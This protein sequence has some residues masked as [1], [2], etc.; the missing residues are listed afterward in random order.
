MQRRENVRVEKHDLYDPPPR[1][2]ILRADKF[3]ALNVLHF[4][5]ISF[6]VGY[7]CGKYE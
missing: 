1:G 7:Q 5:T 2:L 3:L 6:H 4:S